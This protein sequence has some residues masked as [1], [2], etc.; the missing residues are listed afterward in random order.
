MLQQEPI[1]AGVRTHHVDNAGGFLNIPRRG[2]GD[3]NLSARQDHDIL[4]Q[5]TK[6]GSAN[7]REQGQNPLSPQ[8]QVLD[9]SMAMPGYQLQ[10][11]SSQ[12][13]HHGRLNQSMQIIPGGAA[14]I[15]QGPSADQMHMLDQ[16]PHIFNSMGAPAAL[17]N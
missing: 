7:L 9:R 6:V 1:A 3:V 8:H 14:L 5:T 11:W 13:A 16:S 2:L 4:N 12:P 15:S 17:N 10:E